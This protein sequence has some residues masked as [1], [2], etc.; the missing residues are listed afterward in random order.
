MA[1]DT[2]RVWVTEHD[3]PE[4]VFV[5]NTIAEMRE[6][7]DDLIDEANADQW[8]SLRWPGRDERT[9]YDASDL[10]KA[11]DPVTYEI[12][13]GYYCDTWTE[14]EMPMDVYLDGT[15][16]DQISWIATHVGAV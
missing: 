15:H 1:N 9:H 7:F 10:L 16:S 8:V 3:D 13:F 4:V 14:L 6:N 2:I 11:V 5:V 12:E